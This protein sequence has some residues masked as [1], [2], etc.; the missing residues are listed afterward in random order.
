MTMPQPLRFVIIGGG[1]TGV[2]FIIQALKRFK[3]PL[4]FEV[5]DPAPELGRGFAYGTQDP[6]HRIN[7]P[8]GR[9]SL[10]PDDREHATKW[11]FEK[12]ILPGDGSN[13]DSKGHHYVA[14]ASY[15]TYVQD[16]LRRM[17]AEAGGRAMLRHHRLLAQN[18][19]VEDDNWSVNLADGTVIAGDE[20]IL[21]FGHAAPSPPFPICTTA[22][23][24]PRLI[25]NPWRSDALAPLERD[26]SVLL[27]G[28]GLTMADMVETLLARG[29]RGPITALSR[30]GLIPRPHG[31]FREGFQ[32]PQGASPASASALLRLLRASAREAEAKGFGWQA[33]ADALR[34]SLPRI[35][36]ALPAREQKRVVDRLLPYWEV[37]RFR[38]GPQ[39]HA[40]LTQA[41]AD[42]RLSVQKARVL[43]IA[44]KDGKLAATLDQGGTVERRHFDGIVLCIGPDRNLSRRPF[45]RNLLSS[46]VASYD[47]LE[48][49]LAVDR[50][51]R[52]IAGDGRAHATIRALGPMT[53]G[54]FGEMTG[55]P[56]IIRHI[57]TVIDAMSDIRPAATGR[58]PVWQALSAAPA[59]SIAR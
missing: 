4:A 3:G 10:F 48:L 25:S 19:T 42:G 52:L 37:H 31:S 13:T 33:A 30:H 47:N 1:F 40:T 8:S 51:S 49:G 2:A 11:L 29:H 18:V 46:G 7:V 6:A 14:R 21:S 41:I 58:Q 57:A 16:T 34:F 54:T 59:R 32:L 36:S 12:G 20:L 23:A 24:D 43:G 50:W 15:G 55:A 5:I 45:T 22:A 35:W 39:A 27:I 56:D 44:A 9:M 17:L 53:R 38:I 26:A 28:T